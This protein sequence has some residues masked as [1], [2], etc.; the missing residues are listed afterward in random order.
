[1]NKYDEIVGKMI[2]ATAEMKKYVMEH[3]PNM[4]DMIE[5]VEQNI[6]VFD[7]SMAY[8]YGNGAPE[9]NEEK[10]VKKSEK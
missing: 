5:I 6:E 7:S 1:M 9:V 2:A 3:E 10:K 4:L 8:G